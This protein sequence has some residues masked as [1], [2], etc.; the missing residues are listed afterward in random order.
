M[1]TRCKTHMEE[2]ILYAASKAY[3]HLAELSLLPKDQLATSFMK[4]A[5]FLVFPNE[6][7]R[8]MTLQFCQIAY[9]SMTDPEIFCRIRTPFKSYLQN[10]ILLMSHTDK[11]EEFIIPPIS[12]LV[13]DLCG[14]GIELAL[15]YT[16]RD[17]SA[18]LVLQKTL[19]EMEYKDDMSRRYRKYTAYTDTLKQVR[20]VAPSRIDVVPQFE[21]DPETGNSK[22]KRVVAFQPQSMRESELEEYI[23][24]VYYPHEVPSEKRYMID[25]H[26]QNDVRGY[27][28]FNC[29]GDSRETKWKDA[30]K[31]QWL[32]KGLNLYVKNINSMSDTS[33]KHYYN[34]VVQHKWDDWRPQGN[35]VVTLY[36]HKA[37]VSS[38]AVTEDNSKMATGA[39]DG[40]CYLWNMEEIERD[41]DLN[42]VKTINVENKIRA[43]KFVDD[44][45]T[46][47]LGTDQSTLFFLRVDQADTKV[48][49]RPIAHEQEGGIVDIFPLKLSSQKNTFI[50]NTQCGAFHLYD[51]RVKKN[52]KLFTMD[53]R[54][55]ILSCACAGDNDLNLYVGTLGGYIGIYDI[56]FNLLSSLRKYACDT[57]LS[58]ICVYSPYNSPS[59][60]LLFSAPNTP[61]PHLDL[62]DM[63]TETTEWSFVAG[64]ETG[65]SG[66]KKSLMT[67]EIFYTDMD[68]LILKRLIK[69]L[70]IEEELLV[71][72]QV[73]KGGWASIYKKPK[74]LYKGNNRL[75]KLLCPKMSLDG[76]SAPF[77][78]AAGVDRK[79]RYLHF[80]ELD[81]ENM[82]RKSMM[83]NSPDNNSYE[84]V[85]DPREAH[86]LRERIIP[87]A[88]NE[89]NEGKGV[90]EIGTEQRYKVANTSHS[91]AILDMALLDLSVDTF[92][93]TCSRDSTVKIWT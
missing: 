70:P 77:L 82:V 88:R 5:P 35:L 34:Y 29:S 20:K 27:L 84:Y 43:V 32:C 13:I 11:F 53:C 60:F 17:A 31:K 33:S 81:M 66:I 15:P 52:I 23:D 47:I 83:L 64:G 93:V 30:Y 45:S 50:Y 8:E 49:R 48:L 85:I 42:P 21:V 36:N 62:F 16:K 75:T 1:L 4:Q 65:K 14:A 2:L 37:P 68:Q 24:T 7:I 51:M 10:C 12:R 41:I 39:S 89:K 86:V 90:L 3:S 87:G 73:L 67:K 25:N 55:G 58:D 91:D 71:E 76:L 92:L 56:R 61:Q 19:K 38:I 69:H 72:D 79:I 78:L 54:C 63:S 74:G 26:G 22:C 57:P 46:I 18:L 44:G 6:W 9:R 59:S 80:G 40:I 28:N